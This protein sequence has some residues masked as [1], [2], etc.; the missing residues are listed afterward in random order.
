MRQDDIKAEQC[1][2]ASR[3]KEYRNEGRPRRSI[4]EYAMPVRRHCKRRCRAKSLSRLF[5]I[6]TKFV[7]T[8]RPAGGGVWVVRRA[9][10]F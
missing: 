1:R 3:L 9:P 4:W 7:T 8:L 10:T 6:R 2:L 5:K